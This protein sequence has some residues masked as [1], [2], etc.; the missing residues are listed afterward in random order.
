MGFDSGVF[1]EGTP[2]ERLSSFVESY[3]DLLFCIFLLQGSD[4]CSRV[5]VRLFRGDRRRPW[6]LQYAGKDTKLN[7]LKG[8]NG[9]PYYIS[10]IMGPKTLFELLRPLD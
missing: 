2:V 1:F 4:R 7:V 6:P 10:G 9:V 8:P 5:A 3:R